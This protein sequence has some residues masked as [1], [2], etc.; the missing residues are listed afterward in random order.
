M[1]TKRIKVTTKRARRIVVPPAAKAA[2]RIDPAW[3]AE[4]LG[5][6]P[7]PPERVSRYRRLQRP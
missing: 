7:M 6:E 2:P 4:Q 3:V 5:A 1:T